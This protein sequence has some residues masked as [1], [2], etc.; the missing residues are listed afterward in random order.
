MSGL[1]T[2]SSG[3]WVFPVIFFFVLFFIFLPSF[4]GTVSRFIIITLGLGFLLVDLRDFFFRLRV[5]VGDEKEALQSSSAIIF[6]VSLISR[7]RTN[8]KTSKVNHQSV[9]NL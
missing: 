5:G 2:I 1:Y 7:P 8:S 3:S 6:R 9:L 4:Y